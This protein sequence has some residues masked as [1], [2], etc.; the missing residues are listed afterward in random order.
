[1]AQAAGR[2]P[3]AELAERLLVLERTLGSASGPGPEPGGEPADTA[4]R[5]GDAAPPE[6]GVDA[7][8]AVT[9]GDAK[10][11]W[12]A[13]LAAVQAR[14]MVLWGTLHSAEV[15]GFADDGA[16]VVRPP[17]G[18]NFLRHLVASEE[19]RTI[20]ADV[21]GE[22]GASTPELRLEGEDPAP[23]AEREAAADSAPEQPE[24][25]PPATGPEEAKEAD[26]KADADAGTGEASA[27]RKTVKKKPDTEE[28]TRSMGQLFKDEPMLQ[29]ALDMFDGE[30]LP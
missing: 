28:D 4:D 26:A 27:P 21:L 2:V 15:V 5:T 25:A 19:N 20:L 8:A 18:G 29:K 24:E 7:R 6:A 9:E 13:C 11:F 22:L 14:S 30:V 12:Q 10:G 3:L 23:A 16:L 1:M 17:A